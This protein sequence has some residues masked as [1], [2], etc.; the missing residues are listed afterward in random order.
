M[1]V[2]V[3]LAGGAMLLL[4]AALAH[5]GASIPL[6]IIGGGWFI[7]GILALGR[8]RTTVDEVRLGEGHVTFVFRNRRVEMP[9][10]EITEIR[11]A[12]FDT[13]FM[14]PLEV[15]TEAHERIRL[16]SHL[17]GLLDL[18]LHFRQLNP[19]LITKGL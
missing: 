7:L 6:L 18:L 10:S 14:A 13:S 17:D 9:V 2:V 4:L 11:R 1:S 16:N 15:S 8:R 19:R 3:G 12:R 5:D